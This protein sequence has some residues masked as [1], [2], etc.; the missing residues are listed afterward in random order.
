MPRCLY[1]TFTAYHMVSKP[2]QHDI[3]FSPNRYVMYWEAVE[4]YMLYVEKPVQPSWA[5]NCC[6]AVSMYGHM[7]ELVV[8]QNQLEV[9]LVVAA[10]APCMPCGTVPRGLT[11]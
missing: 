3:I 9:F 5:I 10:P 7:L 11:E 4:V 6:S 1:V 2:V 8:A